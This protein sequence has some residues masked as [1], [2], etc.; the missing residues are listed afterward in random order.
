MLQEYRKK[1]AQLQTTEEEKQMLQ[2]ENAR[3]REEMQDR[4]IFYRY[5]W[6][7]Y[8]DCMDSFQYVP[9]MPSFLFS[10]DFS[11]AFLHKMRGKKK[12][13]KVSAEKNCNLEPSDTY[14][15]KNPCFHLSVCSFEEFVTLI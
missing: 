7:V 8:N 9:G 14:L 1:I 4:Y 3:L 6:G 2:L 10:T 13:K 15:V 5:I 12:R 11:L